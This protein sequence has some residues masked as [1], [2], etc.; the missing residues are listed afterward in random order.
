MKNLYT[1]F[2]KG[3]GGHLGPCSYMYVDSILR[4]RTCFFLVRSSQICID[5]QDSVR[6][7]ECCVRIKGNWSLFQILNAVLCMQ[8]SWFNT[9]G[10]F[11]REC[12]SRL[13]WITSRDKF[14][15]PRSASNFSRKEGIIIKP[16]EYEYTQ[17]NYNVRYRFY[18][19]ISF[20][21]Q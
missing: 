18:P 17:G 10:N 13:T 16:L 1:G 3:Q 4:F 19:S 6:K 15:K 2:W 7:L 11:H 8:N 20:C 21:Q 5:S 14:W 12:G 9:A